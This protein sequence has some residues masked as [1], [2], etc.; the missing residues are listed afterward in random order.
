MPLGQW[1]KTVAS[2]F[3]VQFRDRKYIRSLIV[4]F[5]LLI[6]A[7]IINIFAGSYATD[8][9]TSAVGDIILS[10]IPVVNVDEVF[11]FGPIIFWTI[12]S[13]YALS[14]PGTI[15]FWIKNVALFIVIR[16]IFITL[17]HIGPFPDHISLDSF[18]LSQH[19]NLFIFNSG[20]DL[21][22]SAHTGF[23]F[24]TALIFWKNYRMRVFC[25]IASLFFGI[26]VLLGHLHYSI[27]VLAAFFITYSIYNIGVR[28][29]RSDFEMSKLAGN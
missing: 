8:H 22:F 21:F 7:L 23:P 20:A 27:D 1:L 17:T 19:L 6:G 25:I 26:V 3:K 14:R 9:A 18:S 11:V 2:R 28:A 16:S 5:C 10:N 29:F 4:S 24:L 15:P 13:L 12:I